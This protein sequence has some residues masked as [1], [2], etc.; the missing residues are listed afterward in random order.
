MPFFIA[1]ALAL[2]LTWFARRIGLA[3]GLVDRPSPAGEGELRELKIHTGMASSTPGSEAFHA[4]SPVR[5]SRTCRSRAPLTPDAPAAAEP[6]V[7][8]AMSGRPSPVRS[9][10]PIRSCV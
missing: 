6:T 1:I 5:P 3:T 4:T 9:V 8:T 7:E 10:K 2:V